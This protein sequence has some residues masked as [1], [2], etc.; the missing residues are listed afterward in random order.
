MSNLISV[1]TPKQK[2]P[3][4]L[5]ADITSE[6]TAARRAKED[7]DRQ[8][9]A[10]KLAQLATSAGGVFSTASTSRKKLLGN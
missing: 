1:F 4:Q 5:R 6:G 3:K 2:S 7:E 10:F 8:K 9:I